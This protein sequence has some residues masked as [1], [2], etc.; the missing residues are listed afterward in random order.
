MVA[1][2]NIV[3]IY[4]RSHSK[5]PIFFAAMR[6]KNRPMIGQSSH[7][8]LIGAIVVSDREGE[9]EKEKKKERK[10]KTDKL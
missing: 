4:R 6:G 3:T 7:S 1:D 5:L 10:K 9:R 8:S 2:K